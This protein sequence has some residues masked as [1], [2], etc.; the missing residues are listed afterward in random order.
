MFILTVGRD[1]WPSEFLSIIGSWFCPYEL[2]NTFAIPKR[3]IIRKYE[4]SINC[5]CDFNFPFF[6][7][8]QYF[9]HIGG[10]GLKTA[11]RTIPASVIG[12]QIALCCSWAGSKGAKKAFCELGNIASLVLGRLHWLYSMHKE[13]GTFA[14]KPWT[15]K[16]LFFRSECRCCLRLLSGIVLATVRYLN[17]FRTVVTKCIA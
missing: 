7:Q 3:L 4:L 13:F 16:F 5:T 14:I 17:F 12:H 1:C 10:H 8:A 15:F 11:A 9:S 2:P 6:C